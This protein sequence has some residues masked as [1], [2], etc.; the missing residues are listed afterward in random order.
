MA[1]VSTLEV[2]IDCT[3]C[4]IESRGVKKIMEEVDIKTLLEL[5]AELKWQ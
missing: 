3:A 4:T 5:E 2:E 1:S